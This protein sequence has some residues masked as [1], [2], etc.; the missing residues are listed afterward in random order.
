MLS[1]SLYLVKMLHNFVGSLNFCY[2]SSKVVEDTNVK[3][4]SFS[5]FLLI[6]PSNFSLLL[7]FLLDL[8]RTVHN[9]RIFW[10]FFLFS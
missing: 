9:L 7:S 6:K 1:L 4:H 5:S 10:V 2:N 3:I 8:F